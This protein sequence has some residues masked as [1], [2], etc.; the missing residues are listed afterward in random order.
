MDQLAIPAFASLLPTSG[1]RSL[2]LRERPAQ[3]I[4]DIGPWALSLVELLAA[5]VGGQHQL[6]VAHCLLARF[7]DITGIANAP[8]EE[9]AQI[10]HLGKARAAALKAA[11]ELGRRLQQQVGDRQRVVSVETAA[12]MLMPEMSTLEQEH[13]RVLFL[14]IRNGV[15]GSETVYIGT[16]SG[17]NV[18]TA[19]IFR[20]AIRR[21]SASIIVAHNHPSGDPTPSPEDVE[22][23]RRLVSA[24]RLLDIEVMDHLVIG[25]GCYTSL[26]SRGLGF[27]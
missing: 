22:V 12:Q 9:L 11:L 15:L 23:T 3:R 13:M 18:R 25:R 5:V 27:N 20:S 26:R 6:E 7:G 14:D 21:N 2:P 16:I 19:E 8:V 17:I 1:L 10:P 4:S 24:G